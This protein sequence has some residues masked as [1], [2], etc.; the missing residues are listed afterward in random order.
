VNALRRVLVVLVLAASA[1]MITASRPAWACSCAQ[2]DPLESAELAFTGVAASVRQPW[3]SDEVTV[4]FSVESVQKGAT[5]DEIELTTHSQS[6]ACGYTFTEGHRYRVYADGTETTSCDGN[7]DLG[8]AGT[9]PA[10]TPVALWTA[11]A[12]AV[13]LTAAALVFLYRRRRRS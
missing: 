5:D 10:K 13:I 4:R 12:A 3:F 7:E 11:T 9:P 8:F 2:I 6:P 1:L